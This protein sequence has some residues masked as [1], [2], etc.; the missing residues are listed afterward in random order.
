MKEV[1]KKGSTV[2]SGSAKVRALDREDLEYT[3]V[4][5]EEKMNV[6]LSVKESQLK[7]VLKVL[8][9][10]GGTLDV[11]INIQDG[12]LQEKLPGLTTENLYHLQE[13]VQKQQ[14][15]ENKEEEN[16]EEEPEEEKTSI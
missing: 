9:K 7:G 5:K 12:E 14:E 10:A 16:K 4:I 11:V 3:T 6:A 15:E 13:Q 2:S 1:M 8:G